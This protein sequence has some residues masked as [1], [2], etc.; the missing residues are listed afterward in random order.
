MHG[1]GK[2]NRYTWQ[3][4]EKWVTGPDIEASPTCET[5]LGM[6][7]NPTQGECS[8]FKMKLSAGKRIAK[9]KEARSVEGEKLGFEG[10]AMSE[11][12]DEC[13]VVPEQ[14]NPSEGDDD[15]RVS[16]FSTTEDFD[17]D[18]KV[19]LLEDVV[20]ESVVGKGRR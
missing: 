15:E 9:E 13:E 11:I 14:K 6:G 7:F 5:G 8:G 12:G 10:K 3:E 17:N 4:K 1:S 19:S 18:N 2:T 20:L 16:L